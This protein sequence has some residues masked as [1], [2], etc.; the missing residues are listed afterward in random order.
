M[1]KDNAV[2]IALTSEEKHLCWLYS[3]LMLCINSIGFRKLYAISIYRIFSN[4][5]YGGFIHVN[6]INDLKTFYNAMNDIDKQIVEKYGAYESGVEKL[7][8]LK[9]I[10]DKIDKEDK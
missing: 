6:D 4:L 8:M 9:G 3:E 5:N 7:H 1:I 10:I 2:Y